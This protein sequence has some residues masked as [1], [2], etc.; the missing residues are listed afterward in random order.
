M[1]SLGLLLRG[2]H[3]PSCDWYWSAYLG[4]QARRRSDN[5]TG[6]SQYQ[7]CWHWIL[8]T[9]P[10]IQ[11]S[12]ALEL[13]YC[14]AIWLA[15][16]VLLLQLQRTFAP[17]KSGAVY[18]V[19]Q[20][21]LWINLLFYLISFFGMLV[22]CV[23]QTRIWD[24]LVTTGHCI[25]MCVLLV[26]TGAINVVSDLSM[27]V[28]PIYIVW[29]LHLDIRRKIGISAVF[30]TGIL[31]VVSSVFRLVSALPPLEFEDFTYFVAPVWLWS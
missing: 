29:N 30:A 28:M 26:T 22:Q 19:C 31:A 13:L 23:P 25:D 5:K 6:L 2:I 8:L 12:W 3:V 15:K 10:F 16:A 24:P 7:R 21:L 17:T 9:C 20:L 11:I 14:I 4:R 27:F 18:I 1:A